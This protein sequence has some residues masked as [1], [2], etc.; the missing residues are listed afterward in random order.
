MTIM[1]FFIITGLIYFNFFWALPQWQISTGIIILVSFSIIL[2]LSESFDNLSV[3]KL[4]SV[5]RSLKEQETKNKDL[6]KEN[7]E[8]RNQIISITSNIYTNQSINSNLFAN[9]NAINIS[10]GK[11]DEPERIRKHEQEEKEQDLTLS[12]ST[13]TSTTTIA[14]NI[15]S[16]KNRIISLHPY[17]EIALNKFLANEG[18]SHLPII[19]D[20]KF[21]NQFEQI[22][23]I[24][25]YSPVF[26]GYM[27]TVDTEIFIEMK[28]KNRIMGIMR[29]RIY[30][31]LSKI[32]YYRN[33][34]KVNAYLFLVLIIKPDEDNFDNNN[35]LLTEFQ[36]AILNGL[37]RIREVVITKDEE[38]KILS[39]TV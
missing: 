14:K 33:I 10:V 13:T 19:R 17:E 12:T 24:N 35:R 30:L 39:E 8:L 21:T 3:A 32:Y 23:P 11:A 4:I 16:N 31:M 5:S 38:A 36:P 37:L 20:A 25:E 26:D 9:R 2:V 34:K 6:N 28:F 27:K 18:I 29:D 15:V 22:D 1:L 7:L